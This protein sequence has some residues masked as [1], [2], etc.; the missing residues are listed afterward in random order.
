[1]EKPAI[2][3]GK[4]YFNKLVPIIRPTLPSFNEIEHN[5][6]EI[7]S[8]GMITNHKYVQEFESKLREYLKVE[9]VVALSNCTTG[10]MLLGKCLKLNGEV[11]TPSF[12]FSATSLALIWLGLKP[13]F[14]DCDL[15]K[16][17]INPEKII[18]KI[19]KKTC[20]ILATHIF[21]NPCN[22]QKLEEISEDYRLKLIFDS[23]HGAGATY[24]GKYIGNFGDGESFS[25]SPTKVLTAGEGGMVTT[26]DNE[27]AECIRIGRNYAN[28][29]NYNTSF[30]GLS[31]RMAE[32]NAIIALKSL[33]M[34]EVNIARRQK[35]V[36][37]YKEHLSRLPGITFQ[38]IEDNSRSSYKDFSIIIHSNEFELNRDQLYEALNHENVMT[39]K[40]FSPAVH[41]QIA[42]SSYIEKKSLD[43]SVTNKLAESVLCLPIYS[44]MELSLV[45][46]ICDVIEKIYHYRHEIKLHLEK[47]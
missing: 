44:H 18:D 29:G 23:A 16:F 36:E 39:R 42:F 38:K 10:L 15:N 1:M 4:P 6:S 17:T 7:L 32:F 3:G 40:Y 8:T 12:T 13:I 2:L 28:P 14:V 24:K 11:I 20:A 31:G 35:I 22:L 46:E 47:V 27:I 34:L 45:R 41:Q 19:N 25:M 37:Y 30:I 26:N 5:V 21:G 9:N 33:E 43:L